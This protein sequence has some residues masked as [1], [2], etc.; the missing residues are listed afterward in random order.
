MPHKRKSSQH[1]G[2][3]LPGGIPAKSA[4]PKRNANHALSQ[5]VIEAI[6]EIPQIKSGAWSRSYL[7]E[8][9]WRNYLKF[10]ADYQQADLD[11][12]ADG[13]LLE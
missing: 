9:L 7:A 12:I 4:N 1:K 10:S 3:K 6:S 8:Q 5:E 2:G 11:L 13:K